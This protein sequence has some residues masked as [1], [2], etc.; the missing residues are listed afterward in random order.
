[1]LVSEGALS[2]TI[3]INQGNLFNGPFSIGFW[4]GIFVFGMVRF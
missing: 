2:W 4:N 1:M 3:P